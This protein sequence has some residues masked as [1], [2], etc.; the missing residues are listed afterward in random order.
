MAAML[1]T[2]N[3]MLDMDPGCGPVSGPVSAPP[4]SPP[5]C[6]DSQALNWIN[7]YGSDSAQ[8]ANGL[9]VTEADIL[10]LSS[11]ES[12][13]GQG[14]FVKAGQNYVLPSGK[15]IITSGG[16]DFFSIHETKGKLNPYAVGWNPI[17]GHKPANDG[18]AVYNSYLDSAKS[19]AAL[20]GQFVQNQSSASSFSSALG[21]HGFGIGSGLDFPGILTK[22]INRIA[23]CLSKM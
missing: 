9:G 6:T 11:L 7:L 4:A 5:T 1:R 17:P 22:R 23:D 15:T 21:A 14:P 2:L 13:W 3:P 20:Y 12:G 10:G 18:M 16:D 8:I 19:F